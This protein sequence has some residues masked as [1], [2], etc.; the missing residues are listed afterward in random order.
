MDLRILNIVNFTRVL[1]DD[2]FLNL[3]SKSLLTMFLL[4]E[5]YVVVRKIKLP[6]K[7][8]IFLAFT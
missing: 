5:K 4:I 1:T 2:L 3:I 7:F 6:N 8:V